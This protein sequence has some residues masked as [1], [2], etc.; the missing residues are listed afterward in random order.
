MAK[1]KR[2]PPKKSPKEAAPAAFVA[3][4]ISELPDRRVME[5]VMRDFLTEL[6]GPT[7]QTPLSKA[8]DLIYQAFDEPNP[9]KQER[10]VRKAL[11]ICPDCAD[12]HVFLAEHAP[13]RKE[14]LHH[15]RQGLEA[16]ERTGPAVFANEVGHFWGLLETRRCIAGPAGLADV[17]WSMGRRDE[18]I[19]HLQEMLRLNPNDNQG[20]RYI[21][22][23]WLFSEAR[24][25]ELEQLLP[26]YD[27]ET[28]NWAYP[29]ALFAFRREGD[30]P[31]ARRLLQLAKKGNKHV[32]AYLLGRQALPAQPPPQ[33]TP[34]SHDEAIL[35]AAPRER[36]E[37]DAGVAGLAQ[38]IGTQAEVEDA[39]VES[40]R[41]A[42][43]L[44]GGA[45]TAAA[46]VRPL[47]GGLPPV[48]SA[49]H[50]GRR[51]RAALAGAGPQ[52]Q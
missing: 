49:T 40:A 25:A 9:K 7:V 31:E 43:R 24:E 29:K 44:E 42:S 52:S 51:T 33:Y 50:G 47:A 37:I 27:E 19:G 8:Q 16:G 6:T 13:S 46:N 5:G 4:P 45:G 41:P 26:Q 12:A 36:L 39:Q 10:L 48:R 30:S 3:E 15:Y 17:L 11:E 1:K 28:A 23:E 38:G 35:Y 32:P 21:L 14:A 2:K 18:A 22:V 34:G 20:V